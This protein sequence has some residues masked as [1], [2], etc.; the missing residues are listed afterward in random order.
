MTDNHLKEIL[1][2]KIET[3]NCFTWEVRD[4][5]VEYKRL[6][7]EQ[8][9]A[10]KIVEALAVGFSNNEILQDRAYDILDIITGWCSP[11]MSVWKNTD[12]SKEKQA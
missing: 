3:G 4:V 1:T 5:L 12:E 10:Q 9:T 8:K 2:K 11:D 6:G 7:G